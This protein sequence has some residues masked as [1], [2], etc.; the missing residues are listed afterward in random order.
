[1]NKK[2][3]STGLAGLLALN[4]GCAVFRVVDRGL[5][6]VSD[7]LAEREASRPE[8]VRQRQGYLLHSGD[9]STVPYQRLTVT[10]RVLISVTRPVEVVRLSYSSVPSVEEENPYL[11]LRVLL[12]EKKD[13]GGVVSTERL[14]VYPAGFIRTT[15]QTGTVTYSYDVPVETL[16]PG[17]YRY[18]W[19]NDVPPSE[20]RETTE[21]IVSAFI[22]G[23]SFFLLRK[24]SLLLDGTFESVQRK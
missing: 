20:A 3:I 15:N 21:R 22:P 24:D 7:S 6:H 1:M 5:T 4:S 18:E 14:Q 16:K 2:L 8:V 13:T 23:A 11:I 12:E 9:S 10:N 17:R 19:W